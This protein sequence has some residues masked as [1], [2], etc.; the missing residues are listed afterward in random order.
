MFNQT[1]LKKHIAIMPANNDIDFQVFHETI[2]KYTNKYPNMVL[3]SDTVDNKNQTLPTLQNDIEQLDKD[4]ITI[5]YLIKSLDSELAKWCFGLEKLDML[6][7]IGEAYSQPFISQKVYEILDIN[8]YKIKPLLILLHKGNP[9]FP[10]RTLRWL[11]LAN[12]NLHHH[13]RIKQDEDWQRLLRFMTGNAIGLVLGGGGLRCWAQLGALRALKKLDIPIDAIGGASAGAIVAGYFAMKQSLDDPLD[14]RDLASVTRQAISIK[15]F[16]WP[17]VSLFNGKNYTQKLQEIFNT[18]RIENLWLPF[19][20]VSTNLA[21][22]R[23]IVSRRGYLWKKIRSSTA[24]PLVFPPVVV[25]GKL[26]LDGG[27]LNNLPVDVMKKIINGK[28]I[29]VA[30]TKKNE[31]TNHYYFPP[32]LPFWKTLLAKF[33]F[34]YK[35]YKFPHLI[36]TFLKSL[37][38]GASAKQEENSALADILIKPDLAQ[39]GLLNVNDNDENE[40]INIGYK[41]TIKQIKKSKHH[42][43]LNSS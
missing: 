42:L 1:F 33:G 16:T 23:L 5:V 27:L 35:N 21:K 22:N 13:I 12:F 19:F 41:T 15:N 18:V 9:K 3:L 29:A 38:A 25:K 17:S 32:I 8:K 34:A 20:C 26:Y 11:K 14:L 36:D 31:D 24:V 40:L 39:F 37:L 28:I 4:N 7:V 10:T 43:N 30:L 6:Y 2:L